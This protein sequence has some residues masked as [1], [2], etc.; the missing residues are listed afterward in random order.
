RDDH[1]TRWRRHREISYLVRREAR[2]TPM[3]H[4]T[5]APRGRAAV[6]TRPVG[7]GGIRRARGGR[8]GR[9]DRRRPAR[10]A[11]P[12]RPRLPARARRAD[13]GTALTAWTPPTDAE[14]RPSGLQNPR[15][16]AD[17]PPM[18]L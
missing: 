5:D 8:A 18:L 4:E 1:R 12:G 16:R 15:G 14:E 3:G 13:P 6:A 11:E 7:P 9:G 10:A 17:A 2:A